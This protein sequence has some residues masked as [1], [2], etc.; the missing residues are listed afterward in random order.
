MPCLQ[1]RPACRGLPLVR[2]NAIVFGVHTIKRIFWTDG[3]KPEQRMTRLMALGAAFILVLATG[4]SS[5]RSTKKE[6]APKGDPVALGLVA[7]IAL[8]RPN[9][10]AMS[11]LLADRPWRVGQLAA[12]L[13]SESSFGGL[14]CEDPEA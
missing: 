4:C 3:L 1:A 14:S 13:A 11:R 9:L 7:E 6:E 2:K 5:L 12:W 8:R 10:I